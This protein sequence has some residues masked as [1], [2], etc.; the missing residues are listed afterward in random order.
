MA[1][2]KLNRHTYFVNVDTIEIREVSAGRFEVTYDNDRTFTVV[3]G[4]AAGGSAREWWVHHPLF[5]GDDYLPCKSKIEAIR[6]GA[7]Y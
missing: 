6:M 3:G 4:V 5:Y 2:V 7:Q 1:L